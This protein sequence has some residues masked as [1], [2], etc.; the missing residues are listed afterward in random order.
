MTNKN[1]IIHN[2]MTV[3]KVLLKKKK[4]EAFIEGL[5]SMDFPRKIINYVIGT[6]TLCGKNYKIGKNKKY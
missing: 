1:M 6:I 3:M 5:M 4:E 2:I